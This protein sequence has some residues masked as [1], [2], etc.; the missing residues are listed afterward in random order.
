MRG[1]L[2]GYKMELDLRDWSEQMTYFLG[3][4]SDLPLQLAMMALLK[5]GDRF[6]DVGTN[7]GMITLLAARLVG[8][9][10]RVDAIE[11]NPACCA[12]VRRSL[13]LNISRTST[14]TRLACL[15]KIAV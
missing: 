5:P 12:R 14:C 7:I 8:P 13:T 10:G 2:H 6:V 9:E 1:K 11:P 3:R 4:H 15:K